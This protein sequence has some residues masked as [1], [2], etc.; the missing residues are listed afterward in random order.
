MTNLRRWRRRG[1]AFGAALPILGAIYAALASV[2]GCGHRQVQGPVLGE[3]STD[4]VR[5]YGKGCAR[6]DGR[7]QR[8][9]T[10]YVAIAT[11]G[12]CR[13]GLS[14]GGFWRV[15]SE[16]PP[17]VPETF[18]AGVS[19]IPTDGTCFDPPNGTDCMVRLDFGS[20]ERLY[21]VPSRVDTMAYLLGLDDLGW[22]SVVAS[23]QQACAALPLD[24]VR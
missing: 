1:S 18:V 7:A 14:P 15:L 20:V 11:D 13:V 6:V 24:T 17:W 12:D 5:I 2:P 16:E 3:P 23:V 9:G 10:D 4:Q 19:Y 8:F 21:C 22:E